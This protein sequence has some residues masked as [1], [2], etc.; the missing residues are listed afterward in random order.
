MCTFIY[1]ILY[2]MQMP[3]AGWVNAREIRHDNFCRR[4]G[5]TVSCDREAMQKK[6]K[7]YR[8]TR[9]KL[10]AAVAMAAANNKISHLADD[11]DGVTC[12]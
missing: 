12:V 11:D 7:I 5:S 6:R 9:G 10:S 8:I 4:A 1:V 3:A 2:V